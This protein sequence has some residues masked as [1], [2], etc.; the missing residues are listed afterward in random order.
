[1]SAAARIRSRRS[2]AVGRRRE[3]ATHARSGKRDVGW[4]RINGVAGVFRMRHGRTSVVG[5][6]DLRCLNRGPVVLRAGVCGVSQGQ[7]PAECLVRHAAPCGL[8]HKRGVLP[9]HG[10]GRRAPASTGEAGLAQRVV[11]DEAPGG[12]LGAG[13]LSAAEAEA[14]RGVGLERSLQHVVEP[15]PPTVQPGKVVLAGSSGRSA[16]YCAH[17]A[18]LHARAQSCWTTADSARCTA[19]SACSTS[20]RAPD[21][22]VNRTSPRPAR[23]SDPTAARSL[24]SST[25]SAWAWFFGAA[26]A[27]IASISSSRP[28]ARGH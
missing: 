27:Q 19:A 14:R 25:V 24:E 22:K 28:A 12:A 2:E 1:M 8:A 26:L 23:T 7:V 4:P 9:A 3:Q 6:G 5:P 11:L 17:S 16:T 15:A 13:K 10:R 18:A 20:T 21:G